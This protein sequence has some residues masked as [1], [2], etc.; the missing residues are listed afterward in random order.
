VE[1]KVSA[2][3]SIEPVSLDDMKQHI[4]WDDTDG[5]EDA[6]I[7]SMVKAAR[8][9]IEKRLN[10]S[11]GP[12]TLKIFF[13]RDDLADN[14]VVLPYGPH[15]TISEFVKID[16]EGNETAMVLNTDY[17]KRGM[18]FIEIEL[19]AVWSTYDV[20]EL[21]DDFRITL[22]CG[23]G[24]TGLEAIPETLKEAIA[25]QAAEWYKYREDYHPKLS[26]E[27]LNMIEPFSRN[28]WL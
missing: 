7:L 25:K 13:H 20:R 11:L 4:K 22:P 28:Y 19:F 16:R 18:E 10:L 9:L 21:I 6:R 27:V 12:K 8:T 15:G 1:V 23:Y 5:A 26:S 17:Y 24:T 14:I 2:D 3:V